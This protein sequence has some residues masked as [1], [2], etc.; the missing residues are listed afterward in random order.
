MRDLNP[1]LIAAVNRRTVKPIFLIEAELNAP[2]FLS[3]RDGISFNDS[4]FSPGEVQDVFVSDN[5]SSFSIYNRDYQFTNG[6]LR[7]SY[8]RNIAKIYS[9]YAMGAG[10]FPPYVTPGYWP[11]N[12]I[13]TP[14]NTIPE[15]IFVGRISSVEIVGEW[16]QVECERD[17]PRK[18]PRGKIRPPLANHLPAAGQV[19]LW[20]G[21]TY[22]IE[23]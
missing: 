9:A 19:V 10:F 15:T 11:D 23:G 13:K 7:G 1:P 8:L 6:A 18:Y 22:R 14:E 12:Y 3:T 20:K 5:E 2:M 16:I 4:F 21:E 17:L